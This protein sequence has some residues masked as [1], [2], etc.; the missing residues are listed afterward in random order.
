MIYYQ[1][2]NK[3]IEFLSYEE[4]L[5]FKINIITLEQY[6]NLSNTKKGEHGATNIFYKSNNAL[7]RVR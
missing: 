1:N 6:T 5:L 4:I 7:K 3:N 2:V